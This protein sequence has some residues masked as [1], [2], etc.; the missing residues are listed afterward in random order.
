VNLSYKIGYIRRASKSCIA[1]HI[2]R[3]QLKSVGNWRFTYPSLTH[4]C[5]GT[6][7]R[8]I[9]RAPDLQSQWLT[10]AIL[11][12]YPKTLAFITQQS[13]IDARYSYDLMRLHSITVV[14]DRANFVQIPFL[15][16][17][18]L[19]QFIIKINTVFRSHVYF[20]ASAHAPTVKLALHTM[21]C[22][23]SNL[24]VKKSTNT[25]YTQLTKPWFYIRLKLSNTYPSNLLF[26]RGTRTLQHFVIRKV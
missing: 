9:T 23:T 19:Q 3:C 26:N 18:F 12:H 24:H 6:V 22:L 17:L 20:I 25:M 2:Q 16:Q 14:L 5:I 1:S 7:A 8:M 21:W 15:M 11:S 10:P 4:R 13:H